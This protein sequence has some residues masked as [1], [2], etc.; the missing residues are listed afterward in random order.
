L[1]EKDLFEYSK[2]RIYKSINPLY[3]M[4]LLKIPLEPRDYQQNV[5]NEILK[6]GSTLVVIPTG[7]GKTIIAIMLFKHL[8][9][10]KANAKILFLAPTK[11]LVEQHYESINKFLHVDCIAITGQIPQKK[12]NKLIEENQIIIATPQTIA[13]DLATLNINFDC[14][15]FDEAHKAQGLYAYTIIAKRYEKSLKIGLTASPGTKRSEVKEVLSNLGIENL[16]VK[17]ENDPDVVS[18]VHD[19]KTYWVK[20]ELPEQLLEVNKLLNEF[21]ND[22]AQQLRTL[23]YALRH[24]FTQMELL[25]I[26]KR[27]FLELQQKNPIAFRS[28]SIVACMLK[29]NHAVTLLETQGINALKIY[30]DKLDQEKEDNKSKA[31]KTI[32][33]DERIKKAKYILDG[34]NLLDIEHPKIKKLEEL[35]LKELAKNPNQSII[36]FNHFR[37]SVTY[38]ENTLNK[39]PLITAKRFVGQAS[40]G[41]DK[42]LSQKEQKEIIDD[43]KEGKYNVLIASSVAEEGLDI[44]AVDTIFFYEPVPSDIRT[45][46]RKGRTGRFNA[47]QIFILITSNTRDETY[48]W[49]A[50]KKEK[51]M[52]DTLQKLSRKESLVDKIKKIESVKDN[53]IIKEPEKPKIV[54]QHLINDLINQAEDDIASA[55]LDSKDSKFAQDVESSSKDTIPTHAIKKQIDKVTI[56]VD[57]RERNSLAANELKKKDCL[58]IEKQLG[59]GDYQVGED[60][61]IERKSVN[62]FVASILDGRLFSQAIKLTA[63]EKALLIVEGD[64]NSVFEERDINKQAIHGAMFSI[65]LEF[66]IPILFALDGY[67]TCEY[68]YELAKREQLRK[69]RP[70]SFRKVVK[71]DNLHIN[72]RNILEGIPFV[73]ATL[74]ERLIK[75]YGSIRLFANTSLERLEKIDK[76]GEKKAKIIFDVLN[77]TNDNE[78]KKEIKG[79]EK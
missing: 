35:V 13:N 75:E 11:P 76:I 3:I 71:S 47:G 45:I 7:L 38:L 24:G 44:P 48:Y 72:Q 69:D 22:K 40:K 52:K 61:I 29:I 4:S 65:M 17:T 63:F 51:T 26:Q 5:F 55:N 50:N 12:R 18:Y 79:D 19:T 67:D 56:I 74:A 49:A 53:E 20:V 1:K 42:G 25:N 77:K 39:N 46:Q 36:V 23:G 58:I 30:F 64:F 8:I 62:D 32:F 73:G 78:T 59:I 9:E 31:A 60:T 43:F 34:L 6:K 57:T 21:I 37:D 10:K 41:E 15:V 54:K 28:V 66:K 33:N 2:Q 68:V 70:T 14:I 16:E 27:T